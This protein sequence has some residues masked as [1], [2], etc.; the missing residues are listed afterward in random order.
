MSLRL[1]VGLELPDDL[2]RHL[3]QLQSGLANAKWVAPENFHLTLRFIG[4]VP[5]DQYEP[6]ALALGAIDAAAFSL[7]L[8]GL[9]HFGNKLP[10]ALWADVIT[11]PALIHLAE[12]VEIA[13]QRAGLTPEQRKFTP[14]VTLARFKK[15]S[16]GKIGDYLSAQGDFTHPP[17]TINHFTLY[18]GVLGHSGPTYRIEHQYPL[19]P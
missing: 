17:I 19:K 7:T 6:I 8:K 18:S 16:P 4:N 9:G 1:F 13:L 12:K 2:R 11:C 10:R 3:A 5:E 15:S 14:H